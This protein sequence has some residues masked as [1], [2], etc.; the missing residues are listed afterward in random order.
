MPSRSTHNMQSLITSTRLFRHLASRIRAPCFSA[1]HRQHT[2]DPVAQAQNP[3][4]STP[5]C[6]KAS[7]SRPTDTLTDSSQNQVA[8]A[9]PLRKWTSCQ[10]CSISLQSAVCTGTLQQSTP[11]WTWMCPARVLVQ[12]LHAL[13]CQ[14]SC[15]IGSA[16]HSTRQR[17]SCNSRLL[18]LQCTKTVS[19]TGMQAAAQTNMRRQSDGSSQPSPKLIAKHKSLT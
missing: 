13:F 15:L 3:V 17:G 19:Q 9:A 16:G 10:G 18:L 4:S 12:P 11:T 14:A 6:T 8:R 5:Y 1:Q 7:H 2:T